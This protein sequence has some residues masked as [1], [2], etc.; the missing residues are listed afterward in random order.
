M[1]SSIDRQG[2]VNASQ[3]TLHSQLGFG[4]ER[5]FYLVHT[6]VYYRSDNYVRHST[7]CFVPRSWFDHGLSFCPQD[8]LTQEPRHKMLRGTTMLLGLWILRPSAVKGFASYALQA[9]IR[10]RSTSRLFASSASVSSVENNISRLDKLQQ[11]LSRRGAPGSIGCQHKNDMV[12]V[13]LP[14][15][16]QDVPELISSMDRAT[17]SADLVNLHPFLYPIA[18]S[19]T[20]GH[21]ICAYRDPHTDL[22]SKNNPHPWPIVETAV[23]APGMRLLALNSEHLMRRIVCEADFENS[24]TDIV[25]AYNEGLGTNKLGEMGLDTPYSPGDV[26]KLGY[27]VDKYLLLRVGPFADL[28]ESMSRQHSQKGDEKSSLIAAETASR[29]LPGFGSTFLSYAKLLRSFPQREEEAR[30][31]A[32][33]CLRLP[34]STLGLSRE[35]LKEVSIIGHLAEASDDAD[36]AMAKMKTFYNK[37]KEVEKEDPQQGKTIEQAVIDE[38]NYLLD[39]TALDGNPWSTIRPVVSEKLRSACYDDL[40]DFVDLAL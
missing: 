12:P 37:M 4:D 13:A 16:T 11:L 31:A 10:S 40:A 5:F 6:T 27:G 18:K 32:R 7:S 21:Y 24:D 2:C 14:H 39:K 1:T 30:D 8:A 15:T 17:T 33:M 9:G 25:A 38:V 20:T 3:T 36:T 28:Y 34:L 29:K 26:E 35:D 22:T 23:G 19:K